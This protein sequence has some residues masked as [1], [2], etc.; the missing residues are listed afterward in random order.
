ME[1]VP[2]HIIS[3][4]GEMGFGEMNIRSCWARAKGQ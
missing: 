2:D 3:L 4:Y 1:S